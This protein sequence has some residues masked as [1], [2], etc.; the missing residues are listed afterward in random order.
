MLTITDGFRTYTQ[1]ELLDFMNR[2]KALIYA[3]VSTH[4]QAEKG[5]SLQ[6]QVEKCAELAQK[7][8]GYKESEL[9]AILEKGEMGD[10]PDR[11]GLNHVLYLLQ[12]GVGKKLI[13]LHP[14]RMSRHLVLQNEVAAK[15][16]SFGVDLEFV[17]F[18]IDPDN[19]ESM[20]MFNI[21]GSIAQYNKAKILANSKRGRL[22]K[23]KE[24]KIPG[25]R[26]IFGYDFDKENDT[27]VENPREKEIYLLMVDWLLHGK[28]GE[29]MNCSQIARELARLNYKPPV[30]NKWYQ[31]TVSRILR[32]EIY[33]GYYFYGKTEV[34]QQ[35]GK[36]KQIKKPR[37]EWKAVTVP[38]YIDRATYERI[39]EKL[40]SLCTRNRGRKTK[41]YLLKGLLRCGRCGSAV[42]AGTRTELKSGKLLLY[43]TCSMKAKKNYEVGTG[44]HNKVCRGPNWRQDVVDEYVWNEIVQAINNPQLIIDIVKQQTDISQLDQLKEKL[45]Q[46]Q[47]QIDKKKEGLRKCVTAYREGLI[48]EDIFRSEAEAAKQEIQELE[49]ELSYTESLLSQATTTN[50][51]LELLKQSIELY[52]DVINGQAELDFDVKRKI[53]KTYVKKVI[54]YDDSIEIITTWRSANQHSNSNYRE[55]QGLNIVVSKRT[56][57]PDPKS[58]LASKTDR[59]PDDLVKK[60]IHW[61]EVDKLTLAEI[62]NK[63]GIKWWTIK[64]LLNNKKVE[65]ISRTERAR[66]KREKHFDLI[67]RLHFIEEMSLRDIYKKYGFSPCYARRVL[68][69]K[70]LKPVNRGQFKPRKR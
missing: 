13:M 21:Q 1:D 5:Y 70:G 57:L 28:D 38:A 4:D 69:D 48:P 62:E 8:F 12:N 46:I 9:L 67:Y 30:S 65:K 49:E 24:G 45:K 32:N 54:L 17:E 19:P 50:K 40:D 44:K 16:W 36:K 66:L 14:D 29:E 18:D 41:N 27:L 60:I 31:A 34:V 25:V 7:K 68:E 43:Y 59:I 52:R 42:V 58:S 35:N 37:K 33:T 10:N 11:P 55:G 6:S 64:A 22:Q 3:R 47:R 53:I 56:S 51:E 23:V 26:K 39:Q 61:Y 2:F 20:L 15:V 63:T